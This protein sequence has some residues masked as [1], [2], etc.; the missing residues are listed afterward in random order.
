MSQRSNR[1]DFT[2]RVRREILQ[3]D[4]NS[5]VICNMGFK[6]TAD[7]RYE[8]AHFIPRSAGGLGIPQNAVVLC[9]THHM[10]MD[11]SDE[12][13]MWL[14]VVKKYLKSKYPGWDDMRLVFRK[15]G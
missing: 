4:N 1:C 6:P 10:A 14:G 7:H 3:R 5:C 9:K 11:N 2:P 15:G 12:R 8:I 13:V